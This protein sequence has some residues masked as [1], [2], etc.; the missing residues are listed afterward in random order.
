MGISRYP[1]NNDESNTLG[2]KLLYVTYSK[3][4]NDWPSIA[5]S[6]FFAELCYIKSG[7][8][9][10]MIEDSPYPVREDDF[11][12]INANVAHTEMSD[13]DSPLEYRAR[14]RGDEFFL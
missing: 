12:I 13:G 9:I 5:H 7:K 11:I 3:Y 14:R 10:Y 6:H 1:L 2:A 4:E 8:G